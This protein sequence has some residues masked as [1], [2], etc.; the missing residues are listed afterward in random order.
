MHCCERAGAGLIALSP[1][2]CWLSFEITNKIFK[3]LG[4]AIFNIV[5]RINAPGS[6]LDLTL[7]PMA[8]CFNRDVF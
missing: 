8:F 7:K 4:V 1:A 2:S 6:L 3:E 5:L